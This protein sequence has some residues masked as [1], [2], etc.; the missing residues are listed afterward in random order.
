MTA[1][2]AMAD[3]P[4]SAADA[5]GTN[6]AAKLPDSYHIGAGDVLSVEVWKE[7][8]ASTSQT[9]VRPDG[10]VS[11]SLIGEVKAMGLTP[12]EF[13]NLLTTRYKE[14]VRSPR[15]TVVVKQVNSQWIYV[16]G[17][18]AKQGAVRLE[19]PM[20]VLQALAEAGGVTVF[21]RRNK[22]Y[23]L[24]SDHDRQVRLQFDYDAVIRGEKDEQNILLNPGDT[25]VVP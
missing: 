5:N 2:A 16:L 24:R 15:V 4:S 21:A 14:Y 6:Q 7:P 25:V 10:I 13:E 19:G 12:T 18:V 11:L 23:V 22:I 8:D 9:Q 3:S 20:R 17:A 1:T